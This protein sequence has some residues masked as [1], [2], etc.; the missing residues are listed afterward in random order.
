MGNNNHVAVS[1]KLYGV[2]V[3]VG[4]HIMMKE[5]CGACSDFLL[6]SGKLHICSQQRREISWIVWWRSSWKSSWIFSP[7]SVVLM[8]L[9]HPERSSSS[10]DTRPDLKRQWHSETAARLKECS[11]KAS[12]S[13]SR[14][15]T[16]LHAKLDADA[17]LNFAIHRRQNE[18]RSQKSTHVKTM[19]VHSVVSCGSLMQ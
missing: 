16:E 9:C 7:F 6:K 14:G 8:V 3:H 19:R 15:F 2:Q 11:P 4:G 1:H 18:T 10:N 17:L 5:Q 12:W 13:I